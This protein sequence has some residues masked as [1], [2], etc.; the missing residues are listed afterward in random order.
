MGS[1]E[2]LGGGRR[3]GSG[4]NGAPLPPYFQRID[5]AR[6]MKIGIGRIEMGNMRVAQVVPA[7][8][9][10]GAA[11]RLAELGLIE[12]RLDQVFDRRVARHPVIDDEEAALAVTL[13]ERGR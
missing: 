5:L 8:I 6:Q 7:D 12:R 4:K 3:E 1:H 2:P 9:V 13:L 10:D 11:R